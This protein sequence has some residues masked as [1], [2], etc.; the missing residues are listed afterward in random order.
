EPH[1]WKNL[2]IYKAKNDA[3]ETINVSFVPMPAFDCS[4]HLFKKTEP[5]ELDCNNTLIWHCDKC[6]HQ[7][8]SM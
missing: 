4:G 8:A 5:S 3:G 2:K 7:T 1:Q 6:G